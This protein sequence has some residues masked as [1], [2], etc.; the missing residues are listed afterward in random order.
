MSKDTKVLLGALVVTTVAII[1]AIFIIVQGGVGATERSMATSLNAVD[2]R[3][4]SAS[5]SP[6]AA[7]SASVSASPAGK[8]AGKT[9]APSP[10]VTASPE[11]TP[12]E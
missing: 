6:T 7:P 9:I 4:H 5:P 8:K 11:A 1:T 2:K 3:M 12:A 10:T